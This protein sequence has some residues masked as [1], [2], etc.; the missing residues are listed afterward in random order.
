[1]LSSRGRRPQKWSRTRRRPGQN[2]FHGSSPARWPAFAR[3]FFTWRAPPGRCRPTEVV[4]GW[5]VISNCASTNSAYGKP[6]GGRSRNSTLATRGNSLRAAPPT[7]VPDQPRL[8]KIT[9]A[10]VCACIFAHPGGLASRMNGSLRPIRSALERWNRR[11]K[12]GQTSSPSQLQQ[13]PGHREVP[14]PLVVGRTRSCAAEQVEPRAGSDGPD[15]R[16]ADKP[17]RIWMSRNQRVRVDLSAQ[18]PGAP[19]AV[20]AAEEKPRPALCAVSFQSVQWETQP[21]RGASVIVNTL[22]LL[23][24]LPV[25]PCAQTS[26]QRL[27]PFYFPALTSRPDSRWL[28]AE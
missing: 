25:P 19:Q 4:A 2:G 26:S 20:G 6:V 18:Q 9:N 14:A 28:S 11:W 7:S 16:R 21:N 27:D 5:T 10:V 23:M 17:G 8:G 1:M 3:S 22:P 15:R 24:L 13:H 12:S